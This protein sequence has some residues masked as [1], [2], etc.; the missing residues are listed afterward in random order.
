[1]HINYDLLEQVPTTCHHRHLVCYACL[2]SLLPQTGLLQSFNHS[3]NE[4]SPKLHHHNFNGLLTILN[5]NGFHSDHLTKLIEHYSGKI[6]WY[7]VAKVNCATIIHKI[8]KKFNKITVT[9]V[10]Y[11]CPKCKMIHLQTKPILFRV[12][13]LSQSFWRFLEI[14]FDWYFFAITIICSQF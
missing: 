1:M 7:F 12:K 11:V 10:S 13:R 4:I 6:L 2:L 3:V 8:L 5:S 14:F 9:I